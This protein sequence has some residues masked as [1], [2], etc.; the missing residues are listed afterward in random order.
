MKLHKE[1]LFKENDCTKQHLKTLLESEF[2]DYIVSVNPS[3]E[4]DLIKRV[5]DNYDSEHPYK[6]QITSQAGRV[7]FLVG[8][9]DNDVIPLNVG[10]C[11]NYNFIGEINDIIKDVIKFHNTDYHTLSLQ[12]DEL[13]F[14]EITDIEK[15]LSIVTDDDEFKELKEL[16]FELMKDFFAE[17]YIANRTGMKHWD[18]NFLRMD[19]TIFLHYHNQ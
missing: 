1:P 6:N 16:A 4:Y 11:K 2:V 3:D 5:I 12:Y 8:R 7:W 10:Q 14:Y 9:T 13:E 18:K 17:Y 15:Y 19:G